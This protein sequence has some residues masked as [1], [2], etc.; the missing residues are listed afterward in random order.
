GEAEEIDGDQ[1]EA[2]RQDGD[3]RRPVFEKAGEGEAVG[4][5][6][7]LGPQSTRR[8]QLRHRQEQRQQRRQHRAPRQKH[9]AMLLDE[10]EQPRPA[11]RHRE[12]QPRHRLILPDPPNDAREEIEREVEI[13]EMNEAEV[14]DAAHAFCLS[15]RAYDLLE[16][17]A[18]PPLLFVS[19]ITG[20]TPKNQSGGK[21]PHSKRHPFAER[22]ATLPK[23]GMPVHCVGSCGRVYA[24]G[25]IRTPTSDLVTIAASRFCSRQTNPPITRWPHSRSR[26]DALR[27]VRPRCVCLPPRVRGPGSV[28]DCW[29]S[30]SFSPYSASILSTAVP[31]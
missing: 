30:C 1:E 6:A 23:T 25:T 28:A 12:H 13:E 4:R 2:E 18:F 27:C 24:A 11:S 5:L 22:K 7:R 3:E 20:T 10:L 31:D 16:C 26:R 8:D 29:L 17:G 15:L 21:A 19:G 9:R 14:A